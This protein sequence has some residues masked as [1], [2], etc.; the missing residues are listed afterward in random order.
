MKSGKNPKNIPG[1]FEENR[2]L[3]VCRLLNSQKAKYLVIGGLACNLHGLIRATKDVDLLIPKDVKN[4]E[5]VLEALS[6][7]TFGIA[8]ELDA[9]EVSRKP[10]TIIGDTPRVDLITVAH[11]VKYEKAKPTSLKRRIG[12]VTVPYVDLDTLVQTKQTGRLQDQ[13]DLEQLGR[14]GKKE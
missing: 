9:E 3:E 13:A 10:F 1:S 4:T 11:Q 2:L 5:K 8:R 7:L 14:I 6:G 12:Q